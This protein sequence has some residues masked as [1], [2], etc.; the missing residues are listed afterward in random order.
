MLGQLHENLYVQF[1][2]SLWIKLAG[3]KVRKSDL[4]E[5]GSVIFQ[6]NQNS[7]RADSGF[8]PSRRRP[9]ESWPTL[10]IE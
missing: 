2:R 10:V 9:G 7:K 6:G 5:T 4:T 1:T 3:M 8:R